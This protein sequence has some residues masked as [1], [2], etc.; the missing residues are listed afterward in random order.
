M[1]K[2]QPLNVSVLFDLFLFLLFALSFVKR[3][4]FNEPECLPEARRQAQHLLLSQDLQ[5]A[6]QPGTKECSLHL[7]GHRRQDLTGHRLISRWGLHPERC[8]QALR[9]LVPRERLL[10]LDLPLDLR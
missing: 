9:P 7:G 6:L 3:F 10:M 2:P 8:P 5:E 1:V 4:R